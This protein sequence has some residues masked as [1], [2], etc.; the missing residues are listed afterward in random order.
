MFFLTVIHDISFCCIA[1]LINSYIASEKQTF[2]SEMIFSNRRN[3]NLQKLNFFLLVQN[4]R[5]FTP[6]KLPV[7]RYIAYKKE[8]LTVNVI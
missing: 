6:Q 3:K 2:F 4:R 1:L 5:N 8:L 7:I